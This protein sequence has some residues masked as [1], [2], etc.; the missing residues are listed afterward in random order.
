[1][2]IIKSFKFLNRI[3]LNWILLKI[4]SQHHHKNTIRIT[5]FF[6][7]VVWLGVEYWLLDILVLLIVLCSFMDI[8]CNQV[9]SVEYF[10]YTFFSII[11]FNWN[12]FSHSEIQRLL[13]LDLL[14]F[15]PN[16]TIM[17]IVQF[18]KFTNWS[19]NIQI[20]KIL[21]RVFL[22]YICCFVI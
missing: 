19:F 12:F 6:I 10:K 14:F 18:K 13:I 21:C 22:F 2:S 11:V 7:I 4:Y 8:F 15:F 20:S 17:R 1:M 5:V 3:N 9:C 16:Y